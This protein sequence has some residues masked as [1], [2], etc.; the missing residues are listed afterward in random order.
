MWPNKSCFIYIYIE[1][2][3]SLEPPLISHGHKHAVYASYNS[4]FEPYFYGIHLA[5]LTE[6]RAFYNDIGK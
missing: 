3:A 2:A 6:P 5:W 1:H 4:L